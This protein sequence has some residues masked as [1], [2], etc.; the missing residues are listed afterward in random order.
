MSINQSLIKRMSKNYCPKKVRAELDG[1]FKRVAS[2]AMIKGQYFEYL[3]FGTKNREGQIPVMELKKNGE[4]KIDQIRIESQVKKF[5]EI[6]K[7]NGIVIYGT[8]RTFRYRM[9]DTDTHGTWDAYGLMR[10]RPI[11][12]DIKLTQ[13]ID[14]DFGDFCWGDFESMDKIQ[15]YKYMEAGRRM[16]RLQYDFLFMVFDY[17]P[18]PKH[19]LYFVEY[20]P[21]TAIQVQERIEETKA[22]IQYHDHHGWEP[23]GYADE[24]RE[25]P[26]MIDCP[27]FTT[28]KDVKAKWA[29]RMK[30]KEQKTVQRE[31]DEKGLDELIADVF[32]S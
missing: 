26:F 25:C 11:I 21:N 13:N 30:K 20:T 16:D 8:D 32:N 15:A 7:K 31:Q 1:T 9:F 12:V 4:K 10:R 3:L 6:L 28:K 18:V 17:A 24:C 14:N 22:K 27:K 5:P 29:A 19:R 23:V 2:E